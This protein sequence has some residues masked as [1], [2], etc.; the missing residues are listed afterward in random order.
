MSIMVKLVNLFTPSCIPKQTLGFV[1][2]MSS[3]TRYGVYHALSSYTS[4]MD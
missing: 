2:G 3:Y 1:L 4:Y